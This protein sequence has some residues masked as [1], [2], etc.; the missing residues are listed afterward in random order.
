MEENITTV[1]FRADGMFCHSCE[2][3]IERQALRT[4]G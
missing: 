2:K 4:E 1:D 3:I